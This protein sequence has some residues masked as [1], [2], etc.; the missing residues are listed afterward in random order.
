[1]AAPTLIEPNVKLAI[2]TNRPRIT[3]L[4]NSGT[5]VEIYIDGQYDGKTDVLTDISGTADFFYIPQRDLLIGQ[6]YIYGIAVNVKG[7]RSVVSEKATFYIEPKLPAPILKDPV[8]NKDD[9]STVEV[10]GWS[11]NDLRI[12]LYVDDKYIGSTQV[13]NAESGTGSFVYKINKPLTNGGHLVYTI[14]IDSRGKTSDR[15]NYVYFFAGEN[16]EPS[17]GETAAEEPKINETQ[18]LSDKD[19]ENSR[20][21]MDKDSVENNVLDVILNRDEKTSTGSSGM[22]NESKENQSKL[23]WDVTIFILF[24]LAVIV[25]IFWVNKELIKEKREQNKKT[26]VVSGDDD[27]KK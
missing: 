3:G 10:I 13:Q 6:H 5:Y 8:V 7:E 26:E 18:V 2:S 16:L 27:Q 25:W 14:A 4:T 20:S 24:L 23:K 22:I 15:S 11:K 19:V 1:V 9:A 17:I 12:N 21:S